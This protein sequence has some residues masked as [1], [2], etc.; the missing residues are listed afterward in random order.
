[1]ASWRSITFS[2]VLQNKL[3]KN[4]IHQRNSGTAVQRQSVTS[5]NETPIFAYLPFTARQY[6]LQ[7]YSDDRDHYQGVYMVRDP[8]PYISKV[9][10]TSPSLELFRPTRNLMKWSGQITQNGM[11]Y[12]QRSRSSVQE[13]WN[14]MREWGNVCIVS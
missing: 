8:V 9:H 3:Y 5:E 2:H 11:N 13:L 4:L 10:R 1:M 6:P 12:C 14:V 7:C